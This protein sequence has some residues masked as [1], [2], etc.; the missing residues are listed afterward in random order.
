MKKESG[1]LFWLLVGLGL[2][3]LGA[4]CIFSRGSAAQAGTSDRH[5][6][7]IMCTGSATS[8]PRAPTDGIWLLD[9]R[10][11]KLLGTIIDRT[12]GKITGWAEVDLVSEF[13]L[14]PRA[15]VH[16]LMTTGQISVSQA[17]LYVAETSSGKFAVYTMGQRPDGV[18][19]VMIRRHDMVL[20]R[21]PP[22]G[23]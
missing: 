14:K 15:D 7:F 17:A 3:A 12:Q 22:Q 21:Q 16:F 11:G 19:G 6:D 20:F 1:R 23:Q 2:G 13:G 18:P 8:N 10:A 5:E 4:A 9:Y